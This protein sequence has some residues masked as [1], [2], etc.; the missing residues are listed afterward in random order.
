MSLESKLALG[1]HKSINGQIISQVPTFKFWLIIIFYITLILSSFYFLKDHSTHKNPKR[2]HFSKE[3]Y[4]YILFYEFWFFLCPVRF[5]YRHMY[6]FKHKSN[7][8]WPSMTLQVILH[9]M[10]DLRFHNVSINR[11]FF[12]Q[13]QELIPESWS[14]WVCLVR[15]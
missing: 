7:L 1:N 4:M 14:H 5:S 6:F 10:K 13:N 2:P 15:Y 3:L 9:F 8:I 12:Y 11:F